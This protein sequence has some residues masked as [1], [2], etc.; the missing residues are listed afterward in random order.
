MFLMSISLP[1]LTYPDLISHHPDTDDLYTVGD[2][3]DV[4]HDQNL[5]SKID[6]RLLDTKKTEQTHD[7]EK[8]NSSTLFLQ[9]LLPSSKPFPEYKP[10][11]TK[12]DGKMFDK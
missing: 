4:Y 12:R 1:V 5:A 11:D 9:N 10:Q 7:V 2:G 8:T 6:N 3:D